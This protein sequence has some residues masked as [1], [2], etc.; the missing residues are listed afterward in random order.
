MVS[1]H[2]VPKI[3]GRQ[4]YTP[5]FQNVTANTMF[6]SGDFLSP[7]IMSLL[8]ALFLIVSAELAGTRHLSDSDSHK[9]THK[10]GGGWPVQGK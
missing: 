3:L 4:F 2:F 7:L 1:F 6:I 8:I 10:E 5:I 9:M